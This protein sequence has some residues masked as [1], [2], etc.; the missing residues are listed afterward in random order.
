MFGRD[1]A[2]KIIRDKLTNLKSDSYINQLI[3]MNDR[4]TNKFLLWLAEALQSM[5]VDKATKTRLESFKQNN[6]KDGDSKYE[7]SKQMFYSTLFELRIEYKFYKAGYNTIPIKPESKKG[8]TPDFSVSKDNVKAKVE[9]SVTDYGQLRSNDK[10]PSYIIRKIVDRI[11]EKLNQSTDIMFIQNNP[12]FNYIIN[13]KNTAI[14]LKTELDP[15]ELKIL[16]VS[17]ADFGIFDTLPKDEITKGKSEAFNK[18]SG[19]RF[20]RTLDETGMSEFWLIFHN[21]NCMLDNEIKRILK[22]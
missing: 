9:V 8:R 2:L 7:D 19:V 11:K 21:H 4:Y 5:D 1:E 18:I 17:S 3:S 16:V 22:M 13:K 10:L 14:K 15:L 6:S 20:V 12:F